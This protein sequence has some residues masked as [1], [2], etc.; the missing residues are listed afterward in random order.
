MVRCNVCFRTIRYGEAFIHAKTLPRV[1]NDGSERV[2]VHL[3]CWCIRQSIPTE[4]ANESLNYYRSEFVLA[5]PKTIDLKDDDEFSAG[6]DV[7]TFPHFRCRCCGLANQPSLQTKTKAKD[8]TVLSEDSCDFIYFGASCACESRVVHVK[9]AFLSHPINKK[10]ACPVCVSPSKF[11]ALLEKWAGIVYPMPKEKSTVGT[12]WLTENPTPLNRTVSIYD[13]FNSHSSVVDVN[14]LFETRSTFEHNS[15]FDTP[16]KTLCNYTASERSGGADQGNAT[17]RF[18]VSNVKFKKSV[19][20]FMLDN[21]YT[22][23]DMA[24]LGI[25]PNML[26]DNITDWNLLFEVPR[27]LPVKAITAPPFNFTFTTLLLAGMDIKSFINAN[28]ERSDLYRLKMNKYAFVAGGGSPED[29]KKMRSLSEN[30]D[31]DDDNVD[32]YTFE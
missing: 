16:I 18:F 27:V 6:D 32:N 10:F 25:H 7:L 11:G 28:Y 22:A 13:I 9:C 29:W 20:K 24:K 14:H 15:G 4:R 23:A 8:A 19:L 2:T 26:F 31:D 12:D 3:I 1:R 5:V 17:S 21:K 30:E